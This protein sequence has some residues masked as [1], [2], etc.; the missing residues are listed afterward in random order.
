M[1]DPG[2]SL[3][4]RLTR[5][6]GGLDLHDRLDT[7]GRA[8]SAFVGRSPEETPRACRC[9]FSICARAQAGACAAAFEQAS[10][11]SP[12]PIVRGRREAA[13][14]AWRRSASTCGGSCSTGRDLWASRR[15][16]KTWPR[17][18][19]CRTASARGSIPHGD[20]FGRAITE[21]GKLSA[22]DALLAALT[23]LLTHKVLGLSRPSTG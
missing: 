13:I 6:S 9:C 20:L 3:D 18:S 8:A 15:G 17:S 21:A 16:A 7:P 10:G 14:A 19:P 1:S 4:I 11:L 12:S 23:D 2:G 5:S 22:L